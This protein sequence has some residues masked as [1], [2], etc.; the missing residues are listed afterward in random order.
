MMRLEWD[1]QQRHANIR[2]HGIDFV[3]VENSVA[4]LKNRSAMLPLI[5]K[6]GRR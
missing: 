2:K 1:E 5:E 3:G 4:L 6:Q